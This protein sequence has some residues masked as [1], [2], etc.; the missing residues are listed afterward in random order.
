[1][2]AVMGTELHEIIHEQPQVIHGGRGPSALAH[3]MATFQPEFHSWQKGKPVRPLFL[4]EPGTDLHQAADEAATLGIPDGTALLMRT[5]GSTTGTGKIVAIR[6]EQLYASATATHQ[7]LRGEG[8]WLA[9]LPYHH[10]AGFQTAF[11]SLLAGDVPQAVPLHDAIATTKIVA[12][13]AERGPVYLSVVP[14]QL[15][16]ILASPELI[17]TLSAVLLLAGGAATA[18]SLLDQARAA[19]LTIATSYGMTETCGGCVYDGYPIGDTKISYDPTGRISL[20]GS[21]VATGYLGNVDPEA[22]STDATGR[23]THHTKDVGRIGS[24]GQCEIIGRIDDAI[25]TGGLTVMPQLIEEAIAAEYGADSVVVGIPSERWGR[26][27]V[28]VVDSP[29]PLEQHTVRSRLK[30]RLGVGWAPARVY[31]ITS[32]G[33]TWP[34]TASGKIDRRELTRRLTEWENT[35]GIHE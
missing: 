11:R 17:D 12:D 27:V 9:D 7:A 18:P 13:A 3:L 26:S 24:A 31:D 14:T 21:M 33:G 8:V 15:R 19:G 28:A 10:I 1:M 6:F 34:L 23:R 2:S 30:E 4:V 16:S 29:F 32:F 5:S 25:T 22:F 35:H 20:S